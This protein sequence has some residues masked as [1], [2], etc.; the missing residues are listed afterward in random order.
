MQ[1]PEVAV[2][3]DV[4]GDADLQ[5]H[6]D[7]IGAVAA[8]GTQHRLGIAQECRMSRGKR[9]GGRAV[10]AQ[11]RGA[12]RLFIGERRLCRP[13][14]GQEIGHR[15]IA[16]YRRLLAL[17]SFGIGMRRI[18]IRTMGQE[19]FGAL[20]MI[21]GDGIPEQIVERCQQQAAAELGIPRFI[22]P[23]RKPVAGRAG[24]PQE[25]QPEDIIRCDRGIVER[26][27]IARVGAAFDETGGKFPRLG[28]RRLNALALA[29]DAGQGGKLGRSPIA[30]PMRVGIGAVIEQE[31][32]DLDRVVLASRQ[33]GMRQIEKRLTHE[34][35]AGPRCRGGI[36]GDEAP[37]RRQI[38]RSPRP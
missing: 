28:M 2:I 16:L 7:D 31:R 19:P 23:G 5:Q 30:D 36:D 10:A 6:G 8:R 15:H 17:R 27:Q 18:G 3:P 29:D 25:I 35:T 11:A 1:R 26:L 37:Y 38:R 20:Q 13:V 34:R 4:G 22:A 24:I 14:P 32:R 33:A 9:L 12:E 21:V